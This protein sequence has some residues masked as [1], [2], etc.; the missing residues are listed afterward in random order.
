MD[1]S[2][3]LFKNIERKNGLKYLDKIVKKG[4]PCNHRTCV[5]GPYPLSFLAAILLF[6]NILDSKIEVIFI[7]LNSKWPPI[8]N[9]I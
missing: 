2:F 5:A 8:I 9:L 3:C 4:L 6:N 7:F 1:E